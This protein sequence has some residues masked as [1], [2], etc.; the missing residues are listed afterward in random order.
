MTWKGSSSIVAA[1]LVAWL[2]APALAVEEK[3]E[4]LTSAKDRVRAAATHTKGMP[5][6]NL[7]FQRARLNQL[8]DRLEQGEAVSPEEIDREINRANDLVR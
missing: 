3:K 6:A 5:R 1:A 7:D 4:E 8:I 2:S